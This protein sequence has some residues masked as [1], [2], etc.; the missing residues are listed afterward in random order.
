MRELCYTKF[1]ML[2][3][4]L[5]IIIRLKGYPGMFPTIM[6]GKMFGEVA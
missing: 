6:Q 4:H 3:F 5:W 1:C 2:S